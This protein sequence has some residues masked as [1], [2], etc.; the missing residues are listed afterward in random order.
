MLR[1][2]GAIKSLNKSYFLPCRP[3]TRNATAKKDKIKTVR[4]SSLN[5]QGAAVGNSL[6][7]KTAC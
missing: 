4:N 1:A 7:V 2:D 5:T 6:D 3:G